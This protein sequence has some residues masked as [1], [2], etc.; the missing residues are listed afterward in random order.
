MTIC[1]AVFTP[2]IAS[3]N[4]TTSILLHADVVDYYSNRFILT[5]DGNIVARLSDGTVVT[6]RTFSMDLKLNRFL[7]AG[8]VRLEGPHV[9]EHGAALAGYPDLDRMYF[10][11]EGDE[12]DR[13]TYYGLDFSDRHLGREQP[14]DAFFFP[15]LTAEKPLIVA[16]GATIFPKNNVEFGPGSRILLAGLYVPSPGYV[17]NFSSNP[18]FYQNAF[19]GAILDI[20]VPYHGSADAISAAHIRYD[21][22]RGAYV[23]FDQHYVHNQDYV[24]FSVNPLTQDQ[25]QW[26]VIAYKRESPAFETRFF[27]QL[28]TLSQGAFSEPTQA[29]SYANLGINSRIGRYAASISMDQYDN[30]LTPSANSGFSSQGLRVAGHPF[31]IQFA[32]QSYEDEFRLG[33]AIGVPIKFQYRGGYGWAHDG[34]GQVSINGTPFWGGAFYSTVY[35]KFLGATVYTPSIKIAKQTS[36]SVKYDFQR[37]WFSLPHH[38]DNANFTA[39]LANTPASPK[40]P[41]TYLAY[42]V[43]NIGDYY[44]KDQL[45]AYPA[46]AD[47]VT[48]EFGT[49]TGLAAFRGFATSRAYTAGLSFT[50]TPYFALGLTLQ[51]FY[52]TPAPVPGLGGAPP[53][54]FA[55]DIRL[56]LTRTI[57]VDITRAYY[58]N[59]ANQRWSPQFGFQVSP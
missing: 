10:L 20:G 32:L 48:T 11:N 13:W 30:S 5:A 39:T 7:I 12:P 45:A 53:W 49:Y 42:S 22:Y 37:Q 36:V 14:G 34:F 58:F 25:R 55:A 33:R 46:Y 56:R 18:N 21:Q 59:F 51:R 41:A 44:G 35:Q 57:L 17:V 9:H 54:Q 15:D 4:P 28:S 24:A 6:G 52:V 31:D 38:V 19:S 29:S 27:G 1:C 43:Q 47:S 50:P 23:S 40:L 3:A 26:N 8:D 2:W 16:N